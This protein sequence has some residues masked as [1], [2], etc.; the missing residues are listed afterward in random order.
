VYSFVLSCY[1]YS[2]RTSQERRV[3]IMSTV[4][5]NENY[6]TADI[7]RSLGFVADKRRFNGRFLNRKFT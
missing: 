4:R 2:K 5:S 7:R 6:I 3:I 1:G